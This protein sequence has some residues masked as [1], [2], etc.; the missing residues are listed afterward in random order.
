MKVFLIISVQ[1]MAFFKRITLVGG[2]LL[3]LY[4]SL[5]LS[6]LI[7]YG[8]ADIAP[9]FSQHAW[10]FLP[11][12]LLWLIIFYI[13]QMYDYY[14]FPDAQFLFYAT[15]QS[16]FANF[17]IT[18]VFFYIIPQLLFTPKTILFLMIVF[19]IIFTF[20]WRQILVRIFADSRLLKKMIIVGNGKIEH[21]LSSQILRNPSYGY[22]LQGVVVTDNSRRHIDKKI[23]RLSDLEKILARRRPDVIIIDVSNFSADDFS[24]QVISDYSLRYNAQVIDLYFLYE[25][26][27][28]KV[29]LSNLNQI[30][31]A[32]LNQSSKRYSLYIKRLFDIIASLI[33]LSFFV[34]LFPFLYFLVVLDSGLPFFYQQVRVKAGDEPFLLYKI[35]TMQVGS[36][37]KKAQWAQVGDKRITRVGRIL[38]KTCLDELPQFW[39]ILI[40]DM[41][42]V[43]PRPERP[44]FIAKLNRRQ[45]LY[46]KRHLIKP[47][48]TGWAQVMANYGASFADADEKLQ[49]DLYYLKNRSLFLDLIII[50]RTIRMVFVSRGGV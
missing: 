40:G 49:Y 34:V 41:S 25:N 37:N 32:N 1:D 30:V 20:V 14:R 38:R 33:G 47:G 19:T 2:D 10:I 9:K 46:Y 18:I 44:E 8:L 7:R 17:I 16:A 50:L 5:F 26:I 4:F 28:G 3:L 42:L 31:F 23:G 11:V 36:E 12:F 39:N 21:Y 45:K 29:P 48:L 35:R 22:K 15:L 27:L 24:L 6:L 13:N 43:G